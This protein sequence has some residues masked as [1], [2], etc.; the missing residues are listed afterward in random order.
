MEGICHGSGVSQDPDKGAP[1]YFRYPVDKS[2][3]GQGTHPGSSYAILYS[4][5]RVG[6]RFCDFA[7]YTDSEVLIAT[8]D[9]MEW[10]ESIL[11]EI[12]GTQRTLFDIE[13]SKIEMNLESMVVTTTSRTTNLARTTTKFED[14]WGNKPLFMQSINA[15]QNFKLKLDQK[16]RSRIVTKP[17]LMFFENYDLF[18]DQDNSSS[19]RSVT[20]IF[21][22]F[23]LMLTK[24]F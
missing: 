10:I 5:Q 21:M 3:T 16:Y 15:S 12:K 9:I 24:N 20:S 14:V 18:D 8:D 13:Y 7:S 22:F 4:L 23:M 11:V 17:P 19:A 6:G 2:G 1:T